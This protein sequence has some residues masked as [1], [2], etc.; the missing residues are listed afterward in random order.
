V[1]ATMLAT[2]ASAQE[3][4]P[5]SYRIGPRD[6]VAVRVFEEPQLN[7]DVRVNEDGTI[8]LPLVGSVPAEGL[9]E[10]ELAHRLKEILEQD[11]LQRAS[12][13]V[14]ILK[15]KARPISVIGA[16]RSPGD[17]PYSGRLSLLEALTAA[18]GLAPNHGDSIFVLRRAEN[19]LTDQISIPIDDLLIR[20]DPDVNIPIFAND[21]INVPAAVPVTVYCLGEVASPGAITVQSTERLTLLAAIARAGGLSE[22]ASKKLTIKRRK[23]DGTTEELTVHYK[24]IISGDAP[25]VELQQ[26]DVIIVKESFF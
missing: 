10:D 20:A 17:L 3:A 7:V 15:Y 2:G 16:V 11:L 4:E 6:E 8:R 18:G 12:V 9:T 25:D 21:L 22:R 24:Q 14:E 23:P 5:T 13:S 19:G 1:L 26:G